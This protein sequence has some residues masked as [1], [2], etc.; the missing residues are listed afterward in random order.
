M[1]DAKRKSVFRRFRET[2]GVAEEKTTT[3]YD[4]TNHTRWSYLDRFNHTFL[5]LSYSIISDRVFLDRPYAFICTA[6]PSGIISIC[7][8][9]H[10][11][12]L[13]CIGSYIQLADSPLTVSWDLS[14]ITMLPDGWPNRTLDHILL[15]LVI[16]FY[17]SRR[18]LSEFYKFSAIDARL[19]TSI[20]HIFRLVHSLNCRALVG[21]RNHP[22]VLCV[23]NIQ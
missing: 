14:L 22:S 9:P 8:C 4:A 3:V 10:G 20:L 21:H 2:D 11:K 18:I 5:S 23:Y 15:F 6:A 7:D 1:T 17:R 13:R 19:H 12:P 16:Y